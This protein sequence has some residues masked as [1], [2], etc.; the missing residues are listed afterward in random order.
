MVSSSHII[1]RR[2]EAQVIVNSN[3]AGSVRK[4]MEVD[5]CDL[6]RLKRITRKLTQD[7]CGNL[8]ENKEGKQFTYNVQLREICA[9]TDSV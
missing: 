1:S 9:T 6:E 8:C 4:V 5:S 3:Y 7:C 2:S